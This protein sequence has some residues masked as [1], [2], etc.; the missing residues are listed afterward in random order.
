MTEDKCMG[1]KGR[2]HSVGV[3]TPSH[4][5]LFLKCVARFYMMSGICGIHE[6][7]R[8]GILLVILTTRNFTFIRIR[9]SFIW[10][11]IALVNDDHHSYVGD[12]C[13]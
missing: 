9:F 13:I 4:E 11:T 5:N 6:V 12:E 7:Q 8:E 10:N 2:V 1:F 3:A